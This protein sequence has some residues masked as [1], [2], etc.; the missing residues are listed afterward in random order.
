MQPF[1]PVSGFTP[2]PTPRSF[3]PSEHTRKFTSKW[4]NSPPE[5]TM[6]FLLDNHQPFIHIEFFVKG[7]EISLEFFNAVTGESF[8]N[9][10][11]WAKSADKKQ[12]EREIGWEKQKITDAIDSMNRDA[13][14]LRKAIE[15][16]TFEKY[17]RDY[18]YHKG[19]HT[20]SSGFDNKSAFLPYP[21]REIPIEYEDDSGKKSIIAK[22]TVH[23]REI[24]ADFYHYRIPTW[25]YRREN[26]GQLDHHADDLTYLLSEFT[27]GLKKCLTT[28]KETGVTD[29][30]LKTEIFDQIRAEYHKQKRLLDEK[31]DREHQLMESY[32]KSLSFHKKINYFLE[33]TVF[34]HAVDEQIASTWNLDI[35]CSEKADAID[36]ESIDFV[37][38]FD[39]KGPP[40]PWTPIRNCANGVQI[41][42]VEIPW[43]TSINRL[44]VRDQYCREPRPSKEEIL[45]S[46]VK[47]RQLRA[48]AITL[49][50]NQQAVRDYKL[51]C[52]NTLV[53]MKRNN[54]FEVFDRDLFY[55]CLKVPTKEEVENQFRDTL[56][57]REYIEAAIARKD[58]PEDLR[59]KLER[60]IKKTPVRDFFEAVLKCNF[61]V[62]T[63][64]AQEKFL[65]YLRTLDIE[66]RILFLDLR[67]LLDKHIE[68]CKQFK[69]T[70]VSQEYIES[71][72]AREAVPDELKPK[73]DQLVK[74][75]YPIRY[76]S[77]TLNPF[78]V[79][80]PNEKENF[81]QAIKDIDPETR[82]LFI[83][84]QQLSEKHEEIFKPFRESIVTQEDIKGI[85][86][87]KDLPRELRTK[88]ELLIKSPIKHLSELL[89]SPFNGNHVNAKGMFLREIPNLDP[90]TKSLYF[91]IRLLLEKHD[92]LL[93]QFRETPT[94][95]NIEVAVA[96]KDSRPQLEQLLHGS[97]ISLADAE[98][99]SPSNGNQGHS[100]E[101]FYREIEDL[102]PEM[103]SMY[104]EIRDMLSELEMK[105]RGI[106]PPR[107]AMRFNETDD[108]PK[109]VY[110]YLRG[111]LS[112]HQLE[113][114]KENASRFLDIVKLFN[115]ALAQ[116]NSG[117]NDKLS[118]SRTGNELRQ[119][120]LVIDPSLT[121]TEARLR[122]VQ[123]RKIGDWN[124]RARPSNW[125]PES[126]GSQAKVLAKNF[127][128]IKEASKDQ[129][130]IVATR[131]NSGSGKS[132][133]LEWNKMSK[134]M[135]VD[136]IKF[137]LREAL[138]NKQI[139]DEGTSIFYNLLDA[140]S[141]HVYKLKFMNYAFDS[142]L[143][144]VQFLD[145]YVLTPAKK[146]VGVGVVLW[147]FDVHLLT[148]LNRILARP[149]DGNDPCPTLDAIVSGAQD[150]RKHRAMIHDRVESE[151]II[152]EYKLFY[153]GKEIAKKTEK[154]LEKLDEDACKECLRV[155]TEDE[156]KDL[157]NTKI[158]PEYIDKAIATGD[159][160]PDQRKM[161]EVWLDFEKPITI[162][163]A[164]TRHADNQK[165]STV[166]TDVLPQ[167][168]A[169]ECYKQHDQVFLFAEIAIKN[170]R[171]T[172][173]YYDKEGGNFIF[174]EILCP[175]VDETLDT[176]KLIQ[177]HKTD[178]K[179]TIKDL[180]EEG[181]PFKK[182]IEDGSFKQV[183]L[184]RQKEKK[185][186]AERRQFLEKVVR[187]VTQGAPHVGTHFIYKFHFYDVNDE[188]F[189]HE[190][191]IVQGKRVCVK[192][193]RNEKEDAFFE[194]EICTLD[195]ENQNHFV[196]Y[197]KHIDDMGDTFESLKKAGFAEREFVENGQ[198]I[199]ARLAR[200]KDHSNKTSKVESSTDFSFSISSVAK[201]KFKRH[202]LYIE[203]DFTKTAATAKYYDKK[204]GKLLFEEHLMT[205]E[206]VQSYFKNKKQAIVDVSRDYEAIFDQHMPV[207]HQAVNSIDDS[208]VSLGE[209]IKSGAFKKAR[210]AQIDQEREVKRQR[211]QTSTLN[212]NATE[213]AAIP[214]GAIPNGSLLNYVDEQNRPAFSVTFGKKGKDMVATF[215]LNEN[216]SQ[217][218]EENLG[219]YDTG[220]L[221]LLNKIYR[222]NQA[223]HTTLKQLKE[224]EV[225]LLLALQEGAFVQMYQG[226][227]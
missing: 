203:V 205:I 182:L 148:S 53:A 174:E 49:I 10:T 12:I 196:I 5:D 61:K 195:D 125:D 34:G 134:T 151:E 60:L 155:L 85:L 79:N 90:E 55:D 3:L 119:Q 45:S 138:L 46:F 21:I 57:T 48:N 81:H 124:H 36:P 179:A 153:R 176:G 51:Y 103:R 73:L 74:R 156:V 64:E 15:D 190:A 204:G 216:G 22:I 26:L 80:T 147:D 211:T 128:E 181:V 110:K 58:I 11:F 193:F 186:K 111:K 189:L 118:L 39:I 37:A 84:L 209:A 83:E 206:E 109:K 30:E 121:S 219:P 146:R 183:H 198:F 104:F 207:V 150:I 175:C 222:I 202:V 137:D 214:V 13:F 63:Q 82:K 136:D 96:I 154:G 1:R 226:A 172:V 129:K 161:L 43:Q 130:D 171:M 112:F 157:L 123:K 160:R 201:D 120:V 99:Y 16:K 101:L 42:D 17:L 168:L 25:A 62:A 67:I 2:T 105:R 117:L 141:N 178:I 113:V 31:L 92:R 71:L 191:M 187:S 102:D 6:D 54:R 133:W 91:E 100:K 18:K 38:E 4:F 140:I 164:V 88:L 59:P 24:Y 143:L 97:S 221:I 52:G 28:L 93:K 23:G 40:L 224:L 159:I 20:P 167:I 108:K 29:P 8:H 14:S 199:A 68:L 212:V 200:Q 70:I 173:S 131:G 149:K 76:I 142:R 35:E 194:E 44:L 50:I 95:E 139:H 106:R 7:N 72:L 166:M 210:M 144:A 94:T 9:Y 158:T 162:G 192:Y 126:V 208:K 75:I 122:T 218:F 98:L 115:F 197:G 65:W 66:T 213:A 47:M 215:I 135:N 33:R 69:E 223:V 225:P 165:I 127:I 78:K 185:R 114:T 116:I 177:E 41:V 180:Q 107:P 220:S 217:F 132:T 77:E 152:K 56:L 27:S 32:L 227:V 188:I 170:K 87:R 89:L 145:D 86:E 184:D 163:E 19:S 169:K